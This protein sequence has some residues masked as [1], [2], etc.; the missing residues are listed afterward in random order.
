VL[1]VHIRQSTTTESLAPG[2][3]RLRPPPLYGG[4]RERARVAAI[5]FF[6]DLPEDVLAAVAGAASELEIDSGQT[7]AAEGHI[8]HS[9]FAIESGTADVVIEGEKVGTIEAGDV[10]GE[11]AVFEAPPDLSA[12]PELAEGG[13]RTASVVATSPMRV[14]ALFKRDAWALDRRAPGV[15][16]RLRALVEEHRAR[17]AQRALAKQRSDPQ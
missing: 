5:P 9:L 4:R 10:M 11:I 13:L 16:E 15:T 14:I 6:A 8:G 3:P 17:D 12:P 2:S 1:L 7:L